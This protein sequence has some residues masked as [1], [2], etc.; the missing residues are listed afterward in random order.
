LDTEKRDACLFL[1]N[2]LSGRGSSLDIEGIIERLKKRFEI[3]DL[4]VISDN[5][6]F[7]IKNAC[8]GYNY[9]A[10]SG[11]D[12]TL[13]CAINCT[14]DMDIKLIYIPSGTLNDTYKTLRR[15]KKSEYIDLGEVNGN[16]FSY[17]LACGSFTPIGYTANL[18]LK[19]AFKQLA[20]F[21]YAFKEYKPYSIN[22]EVKA[23]DFCFKDTFTLIMVINSKR[24]FGFPF[25]KLYE[26]NSGKAHLLLIKSPQGNYL[27]KLLKM[28]IMFFRAFFIGFKKEMEGKYITFKEVSE[29]SI[30]LNSDIDF[31][32][33]GEKIVL[34]K[35]NIIKIHKDK[36][37][38]LYL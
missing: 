35:E 12:G 21:L 33:D 37:K 24:V 27:T 22:A 6:Y 30:N 34:N 38:L 29:L 9:L 28:F 23:V 4:K 7:D 20:Y 13:N 16:L 19:K 25:N 26:N 8:V 36:I 10:V 5:N 15:T 2:T 3:V 31:C 17:V 32:I 1:A 14:K 11:G 18:R